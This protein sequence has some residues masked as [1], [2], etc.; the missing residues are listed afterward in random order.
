MHIHEINFYLKRK[1]KDKKRRE[2]WLIDRVGSLAVQWYFRLLR[3]KDE[4]IKYSS[5]LIIALT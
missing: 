4:L 5:H 2:N 3:Y 1:S